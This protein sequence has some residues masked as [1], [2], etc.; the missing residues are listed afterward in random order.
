MQKDWINWSGSLKF[1]PTHYLLP[2]NEGAIISAIQ[3]AGKENK[4]LR[5]AGA[6]H[7]SSPL[8]QTNDVLL[9]L[10]KQK[11]LLSADPQRHLATIQAGLTIHEAGIEL[12]KQG[13]SMHNTGDVD[14]Q[15]VA[16]AIA[17][18]THGAGKKLQNLSAMLYGARLING[19]GEVVETD[20]EKDPELMKALRV[21]L[22]T[23]G[24]FTA[25]KLKLLPAYRLDRKEYFTDTDACMEHWE[26]LSEQNRN[27]DFYWYPRNDRVKIRIMNQPGEGMQNLAFAR[28]DEHEEG[29]SMQ[30]LPKKRDLKFDEMEYALP[31]EAGIECFLRIRERIKKKHRQIIAWRLLIRTV[32]SDDNYLSTAYKRETMTISLHHNAGLPFEHYFNDIEPLFREYGGRPH[33]GK[34]HNLQAADL[35][36]LYPEWETFHRY[37]SRLDP[38]N[39]FMTPY[40]QKLLLNDE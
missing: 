18:A 37:R 36:K 25:L 33:W 14:V 16:G 29:W 34:K 2:E 13:L 31:A 24:V 17:T 40:L 22:G 3:K 27:F 4:K 6:G 8:V 5:V 35:R 38:E 21:N 1:S 39:R 10:T 12:Q 28:L 19:L 11:Q 26:E 7:S 32:K 15:L 20:E 23:M 9:S 30:M